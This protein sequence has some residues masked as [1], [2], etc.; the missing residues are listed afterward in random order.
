LIYC[1]YTEFL[2]LK[3]SRKKRRRRRKKCLL[4][5]KKE[6]KKEVFVV[7]EIS[8]FKVFVVYG[9]S[10]FNLVKWANGISLNQKVNAVV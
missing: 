5:Q 4:Y 2:R 1:R 10:R 9:I 8:R 6:R 3:G 7:Y